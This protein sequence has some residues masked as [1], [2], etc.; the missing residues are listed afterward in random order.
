MIRIVDVAEFQGTVSWRLVA[1]SGIAGAIHKATQY[2]VDYQHV[3]N[4]AGIPAIG[5]PHGFYHFLNPDQD[6]TQQASFFL[7]QADVFDSGTFPPVVDFERYKGVL[8]SGDTLDA[9]LKELETCPAGRP[10][11]YG[12]RGELAT[13]GTRFVG[14]VDVWLADY[15][16]NNGN[17]N[18]DPLAIR[19][20]TLFPVNDVK[21]W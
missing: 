7:T 4:H 14:R 13:L 8:P 19:A 17:M 9:F 5:L 16:P 15:G 10:L 6:G 1:A 12:N 20:S 11:L 18:G 21:M 3:A 2:R